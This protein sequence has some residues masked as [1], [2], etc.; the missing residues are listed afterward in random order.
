MTEKVTAYDL[1]YLHNNPFE[2]ITANILLNNIDKV[3]PKQ[4]NF[5]KENQ[6]KQVENEN[7]YIKSKIYNTFSLLGNI[8]SWNR[9]TEPVISAIEELYKQQ[10][11]ALTYEAWL[12]ASLRLDLLEHNDTWKNEIESDL[13]DYR[14]VQQQ[15]EELQQCRLNKDYHQILYII[16]TCWKRD[17]AG[18]NNELLYKKCHV[19]TKKLISQYIEECVQCLSTL[20]SEDCDLDDEYILDVLLESKRNYGRGAI[21]MSGGGTLGLI[22]IGVFSTLLEQDLFPKIVSGSSCGSIVSSIMCSK[23]SD[24]IKEILSSLFDKTFEVF[25]VETDHDTFY[26]HL[27]RFL[28]YGVWFDSKYLQQTMKTFLGNMTF[29]EAFNK[30]GR[31][32][33]ITVSSATIHDQ[34][35]LLNYLTA[36]NVLIRSAVCASCSLPIVFASST[37]YEKIAETGEIIEWSNPMLKFVDGSL[38]SDLP[39]SRLSEMFNVN[40]SIACQ[41]NPHISPFVKFS[42][43]CNE[44]NN[45]STSL[46]NLKS[47]IYKLSGLLSMELSHY[48]DIMNELGIMSNLATKLRQLMSQSYSGDITIL[49][50]L[51]LGDQ[52]KILVNPT[53]AFIWDCI[54]Q[55]ARA[56][57]PKLSMIKDQYTVE[58]SMDKYISVLRSRVVF[59]STKD[60]NKNLKQ[61]KDTSV[62]CDSSPLKVV[63]TDAVSKPPFINDEE[64]RKRGETITL[65]DKLRNRELSGISPYSSKVNLHRKPKSPTGKSKQKKSI[66][67]EF[68]FNPKQEL[69]RPEHSFE[70][71]RNLQK[72]EIINNKRKHT[73]SLS[74]TLIP[75]PYQVV[76]TNE[77]I[78]VSKQIV[79]TEG[80][81]ASTSSGITL[82]FK[83]SKY[84]KRP[85]SAG[86]YPTE[87]AYFKNKKQ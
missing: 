87:I 58:I 62:S 83:D 32:L 29:R 42:A 63:T 60:V 69:L 54:L 37:I 11:E 19:G 76:D 59:E 50:K 33:N 57:W 5:N 27:S 49:P 23:T 13:Y 77:N 86:I 80:R 25:N 6:N 46:W 52:S 48:C 14:A 2:N 84:D 12:E 75:G 1:S 38:N 78:D 67:V 3:F 15:L 68:S 39:I 43:E 55:G 79:D 4:E 18:I 81:R 36:P 34:P 41:V 20:V 72:Y 8:V 85:S 24:E 61:L 66:K 35:T 40:H 31:I 16:R 74:Y 9:S 28:K 51:S 26:T 65:S 64:N 53:P 71:L 21:T 7:E 30:T 73:R 70:S 45:E 47:L 22:G 17:F 44:G 10:S 56:T 82:E